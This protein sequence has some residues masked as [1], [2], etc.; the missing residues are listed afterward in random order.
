M[1]FTC[2]DELALHMNRNIHASMGE[3][4]LKLARRVC[5]TLTCYLTYFNFI[6]QKNETT[7]WK[8]KKDI[9]SKHS[10]RTRQ[11]KK[12]LA[13]FRLSELTG[14]SILQVNMMRL[15]KK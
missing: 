5:S 15:M 10:Y 7:A 4:V 2:C 8:I 3:V 6:L 13:A 12:N 1:S 11:S 9:I 14:R